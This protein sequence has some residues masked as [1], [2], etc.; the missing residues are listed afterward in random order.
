VEYI[1]EQGGLGSCGCI[2]ALLTNQKWWV[3]YS[4]LMFV[5]RLDEEE[6]W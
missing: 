1:R 5:E 3:K 4:E 2:N 6:N